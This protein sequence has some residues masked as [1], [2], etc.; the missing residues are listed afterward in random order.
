MWSAMGKAHSAITEAYDQHKQCNRC[1]IDRPFTRPNLFLEIDFN[2]RAL[3]ELSEK[4][5]SEKI[6]LRK[7]RDK[8]ADTNTNTSESHKEKAARQKAPVTR[9]KQEAVT[10][11]ET[12]TNSRAS[13]SYVPLST[14]MIL[15]PHLWLAIKS[16]LRDPV[17]PDKTTLATLA[18]ASISSSQLALQSIRCIQLP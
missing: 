8:L 1:P 12:H 14:R 17:P 4:I 11:E 7:I 15:T 5:G 2:P 10:N 6:G 16:Q 3:G 18:T 9:D 13:P